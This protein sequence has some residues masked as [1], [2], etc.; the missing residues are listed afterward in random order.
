MAARMYACLIVAC[1]GTEAS[2]QNPST[3]SAL[4]VFMRLLRWIRFGIGD[5]DKRLTIFLRVVDV[6]QRRRVV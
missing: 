4:A 3:R 2:W 1:D 6:A 5:G